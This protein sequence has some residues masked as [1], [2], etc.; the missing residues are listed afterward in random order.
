VRLFCIFE[1]NNNIAIFKLCIFAGVKDEWD[2][3]YVSVSRAIY[4]LIG[5]LLTSHESIVLNTKTPIPKTL[6]MY[7]TQL[8]SRCQFHQCFTHKFFV[9]IFCQSQNVTGKSCQKRLS[10][11]KLSRI[12]LMKLTPVRGFRPP[13][14][15]HSVKYHRF[16]KSFTMTT[17]KRRPLWKNEFFNFRLLS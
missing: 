1:T 12:T 3:S 6:E 10:Y 15:T 4:T 8:C 9:Q 5:V 2:R 11:E 14:Q 16:T 7:A 13:F 17:K